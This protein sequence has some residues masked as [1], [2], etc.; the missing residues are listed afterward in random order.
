MKFATKIKKVNPEKGY[1]LLKKNET[2]QQAAFLIKKGQVVAF[3]TETV[4]GL[5]AAADNQEA[6][7]AIYEV[8]GRPVDNP[9]IVHISE[10]EQLFDVI[11][12]RIPELANRLI[13]SFWPGPL[14]IIFPKN[15]KIP[16]ITTA[17]LKTVAVR[18]P[19]FS[20]TRA[21]ITLT[22]TPLA[23]PSANS[24]GYPS[25][26]L[27]CHVYEDLKGKIPMIIDGGA[28]NVGLESTVLDISNH[29]ATI[30]RPGAI[31]SKELARVIGF[32]PEIIK[33]KKPEKTPASPGMKYR[34]YSPN[35]PLILINKNKFGAINRLISRYNSNK[36]AILVTSENKDIIEKENNINIIKMG[37]NNKK[38]EIA[39]NLFAILRKLDQENYDLILVETLENEGLGEAIM[40]RLNKA[41]VDEY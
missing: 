35:T 8:K 2:L 10:K 11:V 12:G 25:P 21:L 16:D 36:T 1:D 31:T 26:T 3:P 6:I 29:K 41:A 4:Y 28:C 39:H 9:L 20:I 13:E 7:N 37:S 5:G 23:A 38:R 34:H 15:K 19:S 22:E 24:S 14:T 32:T 18:M 17:G 40:N 33:N 30:L 27:A